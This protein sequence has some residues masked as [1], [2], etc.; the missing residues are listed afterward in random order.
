MNKVVLHCRAG[1][2]KD[3]AAE[4]Q[5]LA[6]EYG[7]FGYPRLERNSGFI[8]YECYQSGDA[9][10]LIR[11]VPLRSLIFTRA[12]FAVVAELKEMDPTDRVSAVL[13]AAEDLPKA[14]KLWV[15]SGEGDAYHSLL[16]FCRKLTVPLRQAMRQAG[17]LTKTEKENMPRIHLFLTDN[18]NGYLGYSRSDNGSP[19]YMGIE[20][21]KFPP[22]APSRSTL[23][24][25][26]AIRYFM[27]E[28]QEAERLQSGMRAVDLGACPGGWT[29][30]LV[31]RGLFVHA[32]DNGPMADNL[33]ESGQVTHHMED[34]F[35]FEPQRK[36]ITWLVC[37]MIEK[38]DRVA[39]LMGSWFA[40]RWCSEAIFNLKLPMKQ[41]YAAVCEC[42]SQLTE[43]LDASGVGFEIQA[44]HLYHDRE[45]ITVYLRRRD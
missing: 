34:G 12:W 29:Y 8:L 14:G 32:V 20:R 17:L 43:I 36:N 9:E 10:R 26:E 19:H 39:Q 31:R 24:L 35:K 23:K 7:I 40:R 4:I 15:E 22:E 13:A 2:E 37:D 6:N 44:K 33:M 1:F 45:E 18:Q 25:D 42:L 21:L 28:E 41:R 27:T 11:E 30:Q 16:T 5:E 38:P 3:C